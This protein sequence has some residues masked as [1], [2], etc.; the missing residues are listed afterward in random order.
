MKR[1]LAALVMA[2]A[3]AF[4][5]AACGGEEAADSTSASTSQSTADAS[6]ASSADSS[7]ADSAADSSSTSADSS[8]ADSTSTSS[9]STGEAEIMSTGPNGET[10]V[11]ADTLSLTEEQKEEIRGM[12][13]T[14]AISMHYGG[15]DWATAQIQGLTD[16]F[17]DLGIEL[18]TTTDANFSAEQ[19][20]SDI[21]NIMTLNP[22]ILISIPV[23]ATAS[24]DA[25]KRAAEAGIT[26][27]FMDNCPVGMTAGEDYVSVVSADNYGNGCIAAEILGEA[28][29]GA[30]DIGMV[31]YDADYF[32]TNQRDQGFRDTMAEKYPD[33]NIVTEQGFTDEN[34][35]SEQGD[36]ILT[37]YPN[38]NGIYAS[39]DIPMEGVLSSVRA[40]GMEGQIALTTIDLGNNIALEIANGTVAGLGAQMP[41][42]QGVA[43]ATL[44][45]MSILGEECPSYVA[46]PAK[47]VD[48]EN[49]LDAYKDVYHVDAPDWLVS[50]KNGED[51]DA[52]AIQ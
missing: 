28:L 17:E 3:M 22:D 25:Y 40:A 23:D 12:G 41:Y 49:V 21:E 1:K 52:S 4:S 14:A 39:W 7:S 45:A 29:G 27:V 18:L 13:L 11:N 36:A 48:S 38:I 8:S 42:D 5:L 10:A 24:A 33:I 9:E 34:G 16:S 35:C 51:V 43:E 6:S 30:G 31:Y 20:V 32:V 26:I 2:G 47:R 46:V 15:N 37:Q 50:A 19:Q 44:A